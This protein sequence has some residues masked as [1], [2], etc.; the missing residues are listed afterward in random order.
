MADFDVVSRNGNT[1]NVPDFS[2]LNIDGLEIIGDQTTDWNEPIQKNFLA[3]DKKV[4]A[5]EQGIAQE[6]SDRKDA[7]NALSTELA[8]EATARNNDVFM[9]QTAISS[10]TTARTSAISN[11]QTSTQNYADGVATS[12]LNNAKAYTD[13]AIVSVVNG[14]SAALDTLKEIEDKFTT[15]EAG[16]IALTTT[17]NAKADKTYVDGS[18]ATTLN[19]AKS[20]ADGK[21][22]VTLTAANTYADSKSATAL[23][24]AKSYADTKIQSVVGAAPA[25]LDTLKEIADQLASDESAVSALTTTV[26]GKQSKI[27]ATGLLKGDGNGGVTAGTAGTDYVIPSGS[28]SGNAGTATKLATPRTIALSGDVSGSVSFDGSAN[29]TITVTISTTAANISALVS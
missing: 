19:D 12:A 18:D 7:V 15:D 4:M 8:N 29:A 13:S 27:T 14:A 3:L 23:S 1:I 22:S 11:L 26:S 21:A 28:I 5:T 2:H 6:V 20:Y 9:L 17:V 16:V 25:A 10:E 24:D